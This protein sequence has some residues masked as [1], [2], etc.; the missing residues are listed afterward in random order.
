MVDPKFSTDKQK[1]PADER[2]FIIKSQAT[3][4]KKVIFQ[5]QNLG[6]TATGNLNNHKLTKYQGKQ[7]RSPRQNQEF[8]EEAFCRR[9]ISNT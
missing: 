7:K 3:K 2:R 9:V 5:L 1:K 4:E 8:P 6:S